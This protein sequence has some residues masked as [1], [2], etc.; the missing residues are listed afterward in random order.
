MLLSGV[1]LLEHLGWTEAAALVE[2][3]F[4]KTIASGTVTADLSRLMQDEGR[5]DVKEV[6]CS[7]F[8]RALIE[9]L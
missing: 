5:T 6:K 8:G 3:A 2:A 9:A 7:A 4:G 1:M